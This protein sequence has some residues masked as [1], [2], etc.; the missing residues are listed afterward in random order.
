M[1]S[2]R[3]SH[4]PGPGR[5]GPAGAGQGRG[6]LWLRQGPSG[7]PALGRDG[8][9]R[10]RPPSAKAA[11]PAIAAHVAEEWSLAGDVSRV[12]LEAAGHEEDLAE[13]QQMEDQTW[14]RVQALAREA[15]TER[16]RHAVASLAARW[17]EADKAW[18]VDTRDIKEKEAA[19]E[20]GSS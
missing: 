15:A 5:E 14:L 19:R 3:V 10:R 1:F 17:R 16:E 11:A 6:A 2:I 4:A 18:A 12:R 20:K 13:A 9:P 7:E 8:P